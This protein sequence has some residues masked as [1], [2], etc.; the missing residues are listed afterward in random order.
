MIGIL[1]RFRLDDKRAIVTGGAIGIGRAIAEALAEAGANVAIADIANFDQ[2]QAQVVDKWGGVDI[3]VNNA[4]IC[5][6]T[7]A[8]HMT[9]EQW[10]DVIDINLKGVFLCSQ[11]VGQQM[12][13]QRSGAIVN[14]GSMSAEIANFPQPQVAYNA[15]KAGVHILTKCL[16]TEWAKYNIRVNAI[17]PGY[18]ETELTRPFL[19]KNPD[20][21]EAYWYKG[22]LQN[23]IGRPDELA[24]AVLY[25]ASEA[26]SYTTGSVFTVD[27]G[28]TCR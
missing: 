26:A 25:L 28:F 3:L 16:A 27:G 6:N 7:P 5:R 8:E 21:A 23:R 15:A 18:V 22:A 17:A 9:E 24:G 20:D 2:A 13:K 12:I 11:A 19:D 10:D 14:V 1:D 4:G